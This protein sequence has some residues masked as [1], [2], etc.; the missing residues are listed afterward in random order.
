M[1]K[2]LSPK[3]QLIVLLSAIA[4]N[5]IIA[6]VLNV[7]IGQPIHLW[8]YALFI[9]E[10]GLLFFIGI[11]LRDLKRGE[12]F[13][14]NDRYAWGVYDKSTRRYRS[15]SKNYKRNTVTYWY[16][17]L[18]WLVAACLLLFYGVSIIIQLSSNNL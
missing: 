12:T 4:V 18:V 8:V 9:C 6:L 13:V 11:V 3:L 17:I 7:Y 2:Q 14:G 5:S 10:F 1:A 15:D 16:N